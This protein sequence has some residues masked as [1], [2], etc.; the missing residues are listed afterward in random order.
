MLHTPVPTREVLDHQASRSESWLAVLAKLIDATVITSTLAIAFFLFHS[1]WS[2]KYTLAAVVGAALFFIFSEMKGLYRPWRGE[3]I[4]RQFFE[5]TF[6]W[7]E[8]IFILLLLA[9]A[10]KGSD[11]YSRKAIGGWLLVTPIFLSL[12][13]VVVQY[14]LHYSSLGLRSRRK[15]VVWGGGGL[16][17]LLV[18][19]IRRSPWLG[20]NLIEYIEEEN[21]ENAR[22]PHGGRGELSAPEKLELS[23]KRGDFEIIYIAM[24]TSERERIAQLID[25][26]ADTTVSVY[27]VPDFFV[28]SLFNGKWSNLD[29]IP[30]ISVYDTPF[31]GV[32]GW[33]KRF[34]DI[35]LSLSIL[36]VVAIPLLLIAI[37]VKVTSPGPVMF[38]QRRYGL[39]GEEIVVWKFRSMTV[40][41]DS[42]DVRQAKRNDPRV[43]PLGSFLRRTS[44]DELPQFINVLMGAMSI[45][46]PRPHAVAHNEFY[47]TKV[48]GYMLRHKVRPGITGWAQIN[49]WRGET[50]SLE[51][52]EKRVE[53]DLWY[54]Q[55]WSLWLD[56]K[57]VI[58]TAF[59]G[60]VG[61]G[62][63]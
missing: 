63:Y 38:K 35:V 48:K 36:V 3:T 39:A 13:R 52:M 55:N 22:A 23:A 25:R 8:V 12:W 33:I 44:L 5:I 31:W 32:D 53:H 21:C 1:G 10:V 62:A 28:S 20:L 56:L 41:E 30:I 26:L 4:K 54:I 43:T 49:G 18:E 15:V 59:K 14:L 47:R 34:E 17:K 51:K 7:C 57:I 6:V 9:Y 45:V 11:E 58:L 2:G 46:G 19:K 27:L 50:D 24:P 61:K 60:F 16:G 40:C 37:A 29:G 42:G